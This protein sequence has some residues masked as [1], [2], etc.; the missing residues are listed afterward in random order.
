MSHWPQ[1]QNVS[2]REYVVYFPPRP[3][4]RALPLPRGVPRTAPLMAGV[5]LAG[6]PDGFGVDALDAVGAEFAVLVV[7]GV[8][9][10]TLEVV[11]AE[12][13]LGPAGACGV[14]LASADV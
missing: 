1:V 7:T 12:G 14:L 3:R 10:D 9:V 11:V 5:P 2:V 13:V 6:V 8:G 4:P